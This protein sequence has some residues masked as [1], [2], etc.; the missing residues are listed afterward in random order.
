MKPDL[1]VIDV[2]VHNELT[3]IKQLLPYLP[4]PW[5][6]RVAAT[7]IG[8]PGH[9]YA[10]PIGF[11]RSDCRPPAG[12]PAGSDPAFMVED[13]MK[14]HNIEYAIL[15]GNLIHVSMIHD[16]DQGAAVASAYN[17]MLLAEWLPKSEAFRGAMVVS[18]HDPLLAAR[19]ID[20]LA[21]HPGIVEVLI[22]S[23]QRAPLGQRQFHPIYEMA[24]KHGL[25][26]AIHPGAE[27]AGGSPAPTPSG[28][29]TRYLEWH[30]ILSLN[31]IGH[32]TSLVCEGVFEKFPNL[33]F[34][35]LEGGIAW[36]PHLMW[37]LDKNFKGLR[38]S[39]PWLKRMPSEYIRDHCL[40]STQ[41]IEEPDDPKQLMSIFD[42]IDAE[43]ILMFSSDYPHWDN[44]MPF[45]ILQKLRPEA[46]HKIYYDNA[47]K[48]YKL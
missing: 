40:F 6:T 30:T 32:L 4:E 27:G 8:V 34:V 10:S 39:V 36:L 18:T 44:D 43:N 33:K 41:P 45:E 26:I 15:T 28:Y 25:P 17:D 38:Q 42:M 22:G 5:R 48:L 2:D 9:G 12:G 31:Y 24:E 1:K 19:E 37:R 47:K 21:G 20:R 23:A 29:P 11:M 7:G 14:P 46:R 3:G 35:M 16:P 13:L